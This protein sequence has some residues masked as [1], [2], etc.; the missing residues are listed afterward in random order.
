MNENIKPIFNVTSLLYFKTLFIRDDF[1]S[2][3]F[4]RSMRP[5]NKIIT[6]ISHVLIQ[7]NKWIIAKIKFSELVRGDGLREK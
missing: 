5:E 3:K 2:L 6:N 1:I 7:Y 4:A